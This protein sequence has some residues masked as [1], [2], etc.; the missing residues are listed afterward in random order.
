MLADL[1]KP[2]QLFGK[3]SLTNSRLDSVIGIEFENEVKTKNIP[4]NLANSGMPSCI[5]GW[6]FHTE[7]SLRYEG[8]EWVSPPTKL[9]DYRESIISLFEALRKI[10]EKKKLPFTNSLRTSVHIHFDVTKLN[11]LEIINFACLYWLLEPVLQHYCG[12]HRQ[13]NLFCIRLR[14]S[15][16]IKHVLAS[17]IIEEIPI[18]HSTMT[19]EN[20]RYS[21]VNFNSLYKF[22]TLEFRMMRGVSVEV[23]AFHWIDAL[24]AIRKFSLLFKHPSDFR[25]WFLNGIEAENVLGTVLGD[26]LA[27][28]YRDYL[29]ESVVEEDLIREG[30]LS[31]LPILQAAP[32]VSD[33]LLAEEKEQVKAAQAA[34]IAQVEALL[35]ELGELDT[36]QELDDQADHFADNAVEEG[37][38]EDE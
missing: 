8:F 22:G 34:S 14:D 10:Y 33:K 20:Y 2:V 7:N 29:P 15:K 31:V 19:A 25:E 4:E 12:A 11:T 17:E 38:Y 21:S 36:D 26:T 18:M 6:K 9:T 27:N 35:D 32:A 13:G 3:K 30:Y 37:D 24:E 28:T 5:N 16:Y 23:D 1:V